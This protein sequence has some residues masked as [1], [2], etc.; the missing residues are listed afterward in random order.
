MFIAELY[1]AIGSAV[2]STGLVALVTGLMPRQTIRLLVATGG[3][4]SGVGLLGE[5]HPNDAAFNFVMAA[6]AL[7]L[8]WRDGDGPRRLRRWLRRTFTPMR[9]TAPASA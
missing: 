6:A 8:W 4:L 1:R 5:H 9:H 7:W 3:F 2:V